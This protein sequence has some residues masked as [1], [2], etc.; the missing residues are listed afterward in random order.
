MRWPWTR[1]PN[2]ED[3]AQ[4]RAHLEQTRARRAQVDRVVAQS[5]RAIRQNH[6]GPRIAAAL[7]EPQ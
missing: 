7:R 5:E 3:L 6:F 1:K 2:P 4:A